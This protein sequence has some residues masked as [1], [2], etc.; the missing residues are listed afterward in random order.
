MD[1]MK[2]LKLASK[3]F[4]IIVSLCILTQNYILTSSTVSNTSISENSA[5]TRKL[6]FVRVTESLQEVEEKPAI[7][8]N[9]INSTKIIFERKRNHLQNVCKSYK[10]FLPNG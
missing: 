7:E 2:T 9:V 3:Y 10:T 4:L 5:K 6:D 1:K 8:R